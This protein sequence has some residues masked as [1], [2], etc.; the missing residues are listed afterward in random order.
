MSNATKKILVP[1]AVE[2]PAEG[3]LLLSYAGQL[4]AVLGAE[5][6]LLGSSGTPTVAPA[7]EKG[8]LRQL[9]AL[10]ERVLGRVPEDRG[11]VRF[12][13]LLQPG[14]LKDGVHAVVQGEGIY[15]VLM[16]AESYPEGGRV[17]AADHAAAVM[18]QVSCPVMVVPTAQPF[19]RVGRL[20]FATDLTDQDPQVLAQLS[21]FAALAGAAITL[22]QVYSKAEQ[23]QGGEM[24]AA[25]PGIERQ[26]EGRAAAFRLLEEED[27]LEGISRFAEREGADMVVLATQ[28]SYLMQRLFSEAYI[29]TR[30]YHT[31]IPLLTFRQYKSKFCAG[32][33]TD[34]NSLRAGHRVPE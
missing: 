22:V 25:I 32:C 10:G 9:Q 23:E 6:L 4:A 30:A 34:S 5:L 21:E 15:L 26:L 27:V 29:Q 7:E 1:I 17:G 14:S 18:E 24:E 31:H 12:S 3:L 33:L 8:G 19:K 20:L 16:Q 28:D 2:K 11:Y 13:C